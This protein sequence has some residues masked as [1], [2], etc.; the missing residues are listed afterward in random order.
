MAEILTVK[1]SGK[2]AD[3]FGLKRSEEMAKYTGFQIITYNFGN[4]SDIYSCCTTTD[5]F[6]NPLKTSMK[7]DMQ[8]GSPPWSDFLEQYVICMILYDSELITEKDLA[9][10]SPGFYDL[11]D[12]TFFAHQDTDWEAIDEFIKDNI[13]YRQDF[14]DGALCERHAKFEIVRLLNDAE[15]LK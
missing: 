4:I 10:L 12:R 9:G 15:L 14:I 11:V 1:Y 13:S 3:I 7:I 6:E 5:G 2:M 8:T